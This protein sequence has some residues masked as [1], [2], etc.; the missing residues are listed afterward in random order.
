MKDCEKFSTG[1]EEPTSSF[2]R[3]SISC[4]RSVWRSWVTCCRQPASR[5]SQIKSRVYVIGRGQ[6]TSPSCV[7]SW[8]HAPTIV[9]LSWGSLIWRRR[10]HV[11][12]RKHVPFEWTSKQE[13]AFNRLKEKLTSAPVLGKPMDDGLFYLDSDASE[14]ALGAALSQ[15][16]NGSEVV[17]A[18]ASRVL[19][20]AERNYDFTKKELLGAVNGF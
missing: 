5:F 12:Q 6:Q 9:G 13:E 17:I 16:Q 14:F 15:I 11:L 2:T 8:E 10:L 7:P 1:C 19:S 20:K 4:S 3:L 18:Y